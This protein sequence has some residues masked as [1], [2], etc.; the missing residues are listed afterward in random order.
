[1]GN[2][3]TRII[4]ML[5]L[6]CSVFQVFPQTI[7]G[8]ILDKNTKKAIPFANVYFNGTYT[9]TS[10]N[11]SGEFYLSVNENNP[12]PITATSVG[13]FSMTLYDYKKDSL[14]FILLEPR[15][16]NIG[17]VII[18]PDDMP[19][20]AKEKI[21]REVFLGKSYNASR[22]TIE[23]MED[24]AL[25]YNDRNNSL[26]AYCE[27]P[28]IIQNNALKYT[29]RYF[30]DQFISSEDSSFMSGT[31]YFTEIPYRHT[32]LVTDRRKN[33]YLGSRMHF[34]R[35]LWENRLNEEGFALQIPDSNNIGYGDIVVDS[36]SHEKFL[37]HEG[38]VLIY[39][40]KNCYRSL[41][42]LNKK[43]VAIE[44]SGYFDPFGLTWSGVM[45][46]Q[47]MADLLPYEYVVTP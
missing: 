17:E 28:I 47:R 13:Y 20:S 19:R 3:L 1:M 45:A 24:I 38:K 37:A 5:I 44:R 11:E 33:T 34:I 46:S 2:F 42:I 18:R 6:L 30:L 26:A 41:L 27:K 25:V 43:I 32:R 22:C 40:S 9:G 35:S 39:Y 4:F 7:H 15:I 12:R 31:F 8:I 29:I 14:M 21:F 16:Y 36:V 23:N 10:A